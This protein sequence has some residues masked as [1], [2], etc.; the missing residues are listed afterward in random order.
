[1]DLPRPVQLSL[2]VAAS[3][4]TL[5]ALVFGIDR[6]TNA[7]EVLGDIEVVGV[8]LG[9]LDEAG[10][11]DRLE[12]LEADLLASPVLVE[13]AGHQ[14]T[15]DPGDVGFDIREADIAATAMQNG[16]SGNVANQFGWWLSR[17]GGDRAH[18]ALAFDIDEDALA[19]VVRD[20][21]VEGLAQPAYPGEVWIE[22]G[23][24]VYTYPAAGTGIERDAAM[25]LLLA[26]LADPTRQIVNLPTR[27][28]EPTIADDDVD[29]AVAAAQEIISADVTLTNTEHETSILIPR[30]VIADALMA[31]LDEG[32]SAFIF[33]LAPGPIVD[34]MTALGPSLETEPVDAEIVIDVE[35]DEITLVPS[36]PVQEPDPDA[37]TPAVWD[38]IEDG[39]REGDLAYRVG[40]EADFS[41]A[42]AEALGIRGLI[43]EFTTFHP[44]CQNRVINI[45]RIADLADGTIVMPGEVF[46]LNEVVGRR[47][48]AKGFVCA[49]ALVG[50]ELV[51][52]G[53][54]C[55]GGG[56]SQF[57]TTLYNAAFFAGLEDVFHQPH[58]VWFSRYPE[59]REATLGFPEP[60]LIF[61]N[62]TENAI[63]VRTSH[64]STSITAKIYG[65]NGG[66]IVEAGLS[67]R[68][69][70][71]GIVGNIVRENP[72]L[73]VPGPPA[74]PSGCSAADPIEVQAGSGG[75][76]VT[77]YRY[78]TYP[79]GTETTEEWPWHYVGLAKIREWNSGDP[80]CVP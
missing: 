67:N 41:T 23:N 10:A 33:S 22:E 19:D 65:D 40:R 44:C 18:L 32:G 7:G 52:E 58:S 30:R 21:E 45:Q 9:G 59:G 55:I 56:T 68:Y 77:V 3:A 71:T 70:Y 54:I 79:D 46:D 60:N 28:L 8:D 14:F 16:R 63:V 50:G 29:A 53:E 1:M 37:I 51:E 72:E 69:G 15:L 35:T 43:G 20:W 13:V 64:T 2:F 34:Y 31:D 49:G 61:R 47:T 24:V 4:L 27:F 5:V 66:L 39:T 80:D 36:I 62:N 38:A 76:S 6:F 12:E 75:W 17:F 25:D 48:T 57:T 78:I 26:A 11:I 42:D 74:D 73:N